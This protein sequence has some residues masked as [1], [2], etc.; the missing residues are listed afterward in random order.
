MAEFRNVTIATGAVDETDSLRQTVHTLLEVCT[1]EDVAEILICC[2]KH[3]SPECQRVVDELTLMK[4]DVPVIAFTQ[5][6]NK[7]GAVVDCIER[8]EGSH[9]I[10][11]DSDLALDL[12]C[13]AEMIKRAKESP[14]SIISSSR[15]LEG[16]TFV[17]YGRLKKLL[18]FIAQRFLGILFS[19]SLTDFTNPFQI[20]PTVLYKS[21]DWEN[22]GFPIFIEMVLKPLRLGY[23]FTEVPTNC[24][25]RRQGE[26]KN[27]FLQTAMYLKTA[28]HIRFMKKKDILKKDS[29]LYK[30]MN[31]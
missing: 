20:A 9:C 22:E 8:A 12:T 28:L 26:S 17:E 3:I 27:S 4:T 29:L 14:D 10:F 30:K 23:K 25:P 1:T 24:Y 13:V 31:G 19:A 16:C 5:K 21:I 11:T 7:L 15:W 2:A 6:R 18:N